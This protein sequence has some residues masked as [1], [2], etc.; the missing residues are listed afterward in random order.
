M[1]HEMKL[2]REPFDMI[3]SGAKTYELR[4]YDQKRALIKV[5]DTIV[6]T[7]MNAPE[8]RICC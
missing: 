6:F 3:K 8:N 4:L 1:T 2:R 5:G 7:E